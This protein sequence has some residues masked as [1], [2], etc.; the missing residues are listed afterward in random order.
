LHYVC[1][2]KIHAT[3]Q[4]GRDHTYYEQNRFQVG[5]GGVIPVSHA[6][7]LYEIRKSSAVDSSRP[8][9]C[10]RRQLMKVGGTKAC[11]N[12]LLETPNY[13]V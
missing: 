10:H 3:K 4:H 2:I 5:T 13:I 1:V 7:F 9:R 8:S 12:R 6:S 11:A